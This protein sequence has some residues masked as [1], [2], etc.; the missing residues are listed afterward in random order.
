[1]N[2]H[3]APDLK[4]EDN[5][6]QRRRDLGAKLAAMSAC[7]TSREVCGTKVLVLD[8]EGMAKPRNV[9]KDIQYRRLRLENG[10]EVLL[11]SDKST[12]KVQLHTHTHTH[13]PTRAHTSIL[14]LIHAHRH[15]RTRSSPSL[16]H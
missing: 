16:T 6:S 12:D 4:S 7:D 14:A 9:E 13:T 10:L 1:M 8:T 11:V 3:P 2:P 5:S 15:E